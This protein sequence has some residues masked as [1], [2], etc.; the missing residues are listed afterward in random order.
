MALL[1][2]CTCMCQLNLHGARQV[3]LHG[4]CAGLQ[5]LLPATW[6]ALEKAGADIVQ[7]AHVLSEQPA[8]LLGMRKNGR[9]SGGYEAD[10][11]VGCVTHAAIFLALHQM[12]D[13]ASCLGWSR[14]L[15]AFN[16]PLMQ[17][18]HAMPL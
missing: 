8:K 9:I 13:K 17:R 14:W 6:T 7:L 15:A 1:Y 3:K 4:V 11:V 5:Y 12:L 10:L 2:A 18:Q 16:A